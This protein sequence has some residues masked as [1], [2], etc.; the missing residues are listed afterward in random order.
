MAS[1]QNILWDTTKSIA[2]RRKSAKKTNGVKFKNIVCTYVIKSQS[3]NSSWGIATRKIRWL[4]NSLRIPLLSA[5]PLTKFWPKK[6][7]NIKECSVD[8]QHSM[9]NTCFHFNNFKYNEW[10][11]LLCRTQ[12][13]TWYYIS[14]VI[15]AL[16]FLTF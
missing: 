10:N 11:W 15:F 1:L 7:M 9:T 13:V 4:W 6:L 12:Q 14:F 16:T 8:K 3:S 2:Y 5:P